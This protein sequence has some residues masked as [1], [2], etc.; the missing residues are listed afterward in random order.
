[1][2]QKSFIFVAVLVFLLIAG[3]VA[4]YAYDS[5]RDRHSRERLELMAELRRAL[6]RGELVLHYQPIVDLASRAADGSGPL[7]AHIVAAE[8]LV[9]WSDR[10]E[11]VPP[12]K[13]IPLAED[14]GLIEQIG[15]WVIQEACRQAVAWREAG[16]L[17]MTVDPGPERAGREVRWAD[18]K[19][20]P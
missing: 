11:L 6:E 1:M 7:G 14:T 13:F 16:A 4:A 9:R 5:S 17:S 15:S 3:A 18:T 8:A 2:R 19:S 20:L 12:L 10:G